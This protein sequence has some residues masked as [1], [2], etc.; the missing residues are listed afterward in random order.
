MKSRSRKR[1]REDRTRRRGHHAPKPGR[2]QDA[3]LLLLRLRRWRVPLTVLAA[4]VALAVVG[5]FVWRSSGGWHRTRGIGRLLAG[6]SPYAL[7]DSLAAATERRDYDTALAWARELAA[8]DPRNSIAIRKLAVALHN[9]ATMVDSGGGRERPPCRTS[10]DRMRR[11]HFALACLDSALTLASGDR[12]NWR[13]AAAWKAKLY[14]YL[15]LPLE[16]LEAYQAVGSV[17]PGDSEAVERAAAV[18]LLLLNP[19]AGEPPET[20]GAKA[21]D[22]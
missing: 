7:A 19:L 4:V 11:E 21:P 8:V 17:A 15:G 10:L 12:D 6:R 3:R 20:R 1:R 2:W 22:P 5:V 13:R 9:Q 14:E 16:A 18:E